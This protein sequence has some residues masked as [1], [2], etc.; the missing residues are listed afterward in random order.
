MTLRKPA[1]AVIVAGGSG[2][3]MGTALPKQFLDL[4][5]KP[6]LYWSIKAFMDALPDV[7]IILVLPEQQIS[8]AQMV[9]RA[10]PERIDLTIVAGGETRHASVAN[11]L[12]E[13][14][15]DAIAMV[16]DGAR[17]LVSPLLIQRC[18]EVALL[19]RGAIPVVPVTDSVRQLT[20]NSSHAISR[21][22]LR[23]VQTP[24]AFDA[25]LLK[26]A[27]RQPYDPAFTDEATVVESYG[28]QV[29]VIEGEH[30]NLKITTPDDL[31]IAEALIR[32]RL[33]V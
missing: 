28:E 23:I 26:E 33:G 15:D 21:D 4:C 1:Y 8:L 17:P 13:V 7:H 24:Q 3:R 32:Q 27:F 22:D 5:G 30:C 20:G 6:V 18:Y 29:Q 2:Q 11:G 10:F 19:N 16:H 31:L 14:P 9:L 12:K 25:A